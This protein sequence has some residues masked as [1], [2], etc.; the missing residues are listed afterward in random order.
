MIVRE[1]PVPSSLSSMRLYVYLH[2]RI[3]IEKRWGPC[4][5]LRPARKPD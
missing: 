5:T 4:S 2:G 1:Q 3:P